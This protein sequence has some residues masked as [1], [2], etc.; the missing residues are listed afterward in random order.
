MSR[1]EVPVAATGLLRTFAEA[2]MI[3]PVDFH[4]ARRMAAL[5]EEADE[6]V[7][8]AFALAT[9]ELRLGSVCLDLRTASSLSWRA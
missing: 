2:T 5:S 7:E 9:R 1:Y 4:L 6:R 3:A 8:L